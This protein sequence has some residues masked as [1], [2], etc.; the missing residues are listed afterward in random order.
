[1]IYCTHN[2]CVVCNISRFVVHWIR[3]S[4]AN[5]T[6]Q[7]DKCWEFDVARWNGFHLIT[8]FEDGGWSHKPIITVVRGW[9]QVVQFRGDFH[10][11]WS[12]AKMLLH[13]R[14][15]SQ[16]MFSAGAGDWSS[17]LV[18]SSSTYLDLFWRFLK[19]EGM[20][21]WVWREADFFVPHL[22]REGL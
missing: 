1:M 6:A 10:R 15:P 19:Y 8:L 13:A 12:C 17:A 21:L 5:A 22:P 7:F 4:D 11:G 14:A 2:I 16:S 9:F 18:K 20:Q 3:W